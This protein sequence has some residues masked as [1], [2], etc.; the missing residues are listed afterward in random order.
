LNAQAAE[1]GGGPKGSV[2]FVNHN[3]PLK[4]QR[5]QSG[6]GPGWQA[7]HFK[8]SVIGM[9]IRSILIADP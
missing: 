1:E 8:S 9:L 4:E 2:P 3:S 7:V 6:G 5:V